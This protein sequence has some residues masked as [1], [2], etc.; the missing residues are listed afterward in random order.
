MTIME[1]S[2][3]DETEKAS[4]EEKKPVE[5]TDDGEPDNPFSDENLPNDSV[6]KAEDGRKDITLTPDEKAA[7]IESVATN[8][9]FTK[10][11]SLFGGK[12]T[13]TLRSLTTDEVNAL[14]SWTSR[15]STKDAIG[16]VSGR[17][18]KFLAAAHCAMVNGVEMQPLDEPLF[19]RVES[20]GKTISPPGWISRGSYFDGMG[21]GQFQAIMKCIED[22]DAR[23]AMLCSKAEDAN[24]WDPD[25]P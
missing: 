14:A 22:F 13:I 1:E 8:E 2:P 10:R 25:T 6:V 11:Y 16:I 23:Y 5:K 7:F 17:Y 20:D 21:Y 12:L 3:V 24:F 19:E 9:R 18:R 4:S 15:Q